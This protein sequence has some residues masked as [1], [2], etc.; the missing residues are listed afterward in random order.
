MCIIGTQYIRNVKQACFNRL[1]LYYKQINLSN[2]P[3]TKNNNYINNNV[4]PV[5]SYK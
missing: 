4:V 3:N 1:R 5:T 2:P